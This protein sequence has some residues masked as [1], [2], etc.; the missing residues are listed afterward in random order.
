[1]NEPKRSTVYLDSNLHR[2][3]KLKAA[4]NDVSIS[5]LVNDAVK[6][7]LQEDAMDLEAIR[8]RKGEKPRSF[9]TFVE[10]MKKNGLL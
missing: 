5:E 3:L 9:E 2:A 8:E 1:M 10:E 4:Q 7:V 6:I